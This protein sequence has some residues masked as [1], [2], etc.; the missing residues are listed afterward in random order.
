M[1]KSF[2]C[3]RTTVAV[4]VDDMAAMMNESRTILISNQTI[5]NALA[6]LDF[7]QRSP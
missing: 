3:D 1:L 4:K 5:A 2:F 6:G 7:G